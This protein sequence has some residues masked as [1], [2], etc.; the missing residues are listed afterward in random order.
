M[1]YTIDIVQTTEGTTKYWVLCGAYAVA[2]F[3]TLADAETWIQN[4][5]DWDCSDCYNCNS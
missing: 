5:P 2:E 1:K 3:S 4:N